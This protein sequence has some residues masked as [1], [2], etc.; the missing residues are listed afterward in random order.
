M[1]VHAVIPATRADLRRRVRGDE[2]AGLTAGGDS[3]SQIG[4]GWRALLVLEPE[5]LVEPLSRRPERMHDDGTSRLDT[6]SWFLL[7]SLE[8][9][10]GQPVSRA[11][12]DGF[13]GR[14]DRGTA[15]RACTRR[16]AA[17]VGGPPP[18]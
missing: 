15:G 11:S 5:W 1:P 4:A 16:K 8:H 12:I 10:T 13:R 2:P 6:G 18:L 17:A 14:S 3:R 7:C 9:D